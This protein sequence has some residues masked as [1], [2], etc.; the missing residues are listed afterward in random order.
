MPR[1]LSSRALAKLAKKL[2]EV[3]KDVARPHFVS[4][5]T[6]GTPTPYEKEVAPGFKGDEVETSPHRLD[7]V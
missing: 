1:P 6:W 4:G 3:V 7:C 2:A 5:W